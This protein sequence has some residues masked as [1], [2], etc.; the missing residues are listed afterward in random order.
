MKKKLGLLLAITTFLIACTVIKITG[1]HN[2][3]NTD[4]AIKASIEKPKALKEIV[5]KPNI[6]E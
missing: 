1:D 2:E 5:N 3:V 4:K 6:R